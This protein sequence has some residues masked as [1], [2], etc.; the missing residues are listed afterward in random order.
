LFSVVG[1]V[2]ETPSM[3][4]EQIPTIVEGLRA[5][6]RAGRTRSLNWRRQQ[7][8]NFRRMLVDGRQELCLAMDQDLR[9]NAVEA[10]FTEI[11]QIEQEIQLHLDHL[12]EWAEPQVV[13][14]DLLNQPGRSWLYPEPLGL[15][16]LIGAWNYP[17]QLTLLPLVGCLSA[18]NCA[19]I[20]VPS[21]HYTAHTSQ[22]ILSLC[23]RY[24]D[25]SCV[26]VVGGDRQMTQAVL[27]ERY[28]VMFFTGGHLVGRMVAESAARN[29]TPV[30]LVGVF[31]AVCIGS[32][33]S[34]LGSVLLVFVDVV[35]YMC[36]DCGVA[37][38]RSSEENPRPSSIRLQTSKWQPEESPGAP[39]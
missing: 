2:F 14:T 18:G 34:A 11:N 26:R 31:V 19:L 36:C 17:V 16:L 9:K 22:A 35:V 38:V 1:L 28:D 25:Q 29:L 33:F 6:F 4:A 20:K 24:L 37:F 39:S 32:N 5:S 12:A 23:S 27:A 13:A 3:S 21:E 15:A 8:Q 7:L 30:V 10:Y